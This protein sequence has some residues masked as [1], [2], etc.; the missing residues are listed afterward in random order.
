MTAGIKNHLILILMAVA[1]F[2][3][4]KLTPRVYMADSSQA[5]DLN[6]LIP[7]NFD[8]WRE[9][10]H[11]SNQVVNPQLQ[12]KLSSIYSQSLSRT[13]VNEEGDLV[14]LSIAY[15]RDQRSEMAVHYPE[16]CYPAQ[17]FLLKSSRDDTMEVGGELYAIR[18]IETEL[19]KRRY[20]PVM[21]W[22]TIGEY[23]SLGGFEKRLVELRYGLEGRIP[24]GLVFRVS[25]IG[26]DS[27]REFK[28]QENFVQ[29]LVQ[30]VDPKARRF[31]M[32]DQ[33]I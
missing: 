14:M 1:A 9:I 13:Y 27:L 7:E 15:G 24:D 5:W 3:G 31:L 10:G 21:Y 20:E 17:G 28:I 23:R 33:S 16:A 30:S 2:A 19:G 4:F 29:S 25:S 18:K 6:I 8:G 12:D 26:M 32:G 11:L 22:T